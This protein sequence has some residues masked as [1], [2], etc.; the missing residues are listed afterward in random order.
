MNSPWSDSRYT[1]YS[2]PHWSKT[3][4]LAPAAEPQG[5]HLPDRLHGDPRG[6]LGLPDAALAKQDRHLR[7]AEAGLHRPVGH[8]DLEAVPVG[9][10]A[11]EVEAPEDAR[12]EALE[13]PGEVADGQA[14]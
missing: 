13:A 8:L 10:H 11:G 2:D 14:Q 7:D 4:R 12:V 9:V 3:L 5:G 6:H 1:K